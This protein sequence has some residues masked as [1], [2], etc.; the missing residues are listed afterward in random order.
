VSDVDTKTCPDC[1]E[2]IEADARV[3]RYCLYRFA[4]KPP[5]VTKFAL[6][7]PVVIVSLFGA[8]AF[9]VTRLAQ[10]SFYS[11]FGLDPEDVGLTYTETLTRAAAGLLL[12]LLFVGVIVLLMWLNASWGTPRTAQERRRQFRYAAVTTAFLLISILILTLPPTYQNRAEDVKDGKAVRPAGITW[13]IF[14]NPFGLRVER[15]HVSWID[16]TNAAYDFGPGEVMYL[17]RARG[18]A[19]FFD[20]RE[21]KQRTVRVPDGGIVIEGEN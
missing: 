19:V 20:P 8:L 15:V 13:R 1:A 10:T 4:R 14:E 9:F 18:V 3:C 11:R 5:E 16:K 6:S 7:N 12:L 17:G 2:E 21:G